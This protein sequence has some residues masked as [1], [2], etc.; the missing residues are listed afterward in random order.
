MSAAFLFALAL[1]FFVN[2]FRS[3]PLELPYRGREARLSAGVAEAVP[4]AMGLAEA[5]AAWRK[6]AA[7]FIDAREPD[8]FEEGH[9]GRAINLPVSK[10]AAADG[11]PEDKAVSLI[12]YCSGG[13]CGDSRIVARALSAAGYRN[14][15]VFSGGWDEW[16][17]AGLSP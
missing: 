8:F 14:V 6:G 11:L 17:A 1:G 12:V 15:A 16:T 7:V 3:D 4:P 2:L 13:D 5:E 9:I 10:I